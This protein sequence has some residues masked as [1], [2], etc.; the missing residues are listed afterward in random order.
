[1]VPPFLAYYGVLTN[2]QT[3]AQLAYNQCCLYRSYLV[4]D[5]ADGMWK[6]ITLGSFSDDGNWSLRLPLAQFDPRCSSAGLVVQ[7]M[8][9]LQQACC[10]CSERSSAPSSR[11]T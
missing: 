10:A 4:D 6:H 3:L 9:G 7:E 5:D 8:A 11:R 2:N 1:M